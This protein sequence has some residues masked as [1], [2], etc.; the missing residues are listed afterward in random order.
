MND[1]MH[2]PQRKCTNVL[3]HFN[4][5]TCFA[6]LPPC[7]FELLTWLSS[8]NIHHGA[9]Y[10]RWTLILRAYWVGK[11][12]ALAKF[13]NVC[14]A[15]GKK[16]RRVTDEHIIHTII[17][18]QS[19]PAQIVSLW[20][21]LLVKKVFWPTHLYRISHQITKPLACIQ[22]LEKYWTYFTHWQYLLWPWY[23]H[24]LPG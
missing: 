15:D 20:D 4:C 17:I 2:V 5:S 21:C 1:W 14:T 12:T 18:G 16:V 23:S 3:L 19:I 13:A 6:C 24:C 11:L 10:L 9:R 7:I 22:Q 8:V